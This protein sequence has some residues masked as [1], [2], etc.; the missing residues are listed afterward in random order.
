MSD[1]L[2]KFGRAELRRLEPVTASIRAQFDK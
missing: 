1:I 2:K